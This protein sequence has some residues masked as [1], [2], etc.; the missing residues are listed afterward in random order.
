MSYFLRAHILTIACV[1]ALSCSSP[2]D[3]RMPVTEDRLPAGIQQA[4]NSF[5]SDSLLD[6]TRVLSS[7]GFEGRAP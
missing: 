6:H 5:S 2:R 7:D 4:W 1:F 3:S